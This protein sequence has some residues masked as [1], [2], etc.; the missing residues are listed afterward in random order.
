MSP[1]C[2][3]MFKLFSSAPQRTPVCSANEGDFG[4]SCTGRPCCPVQFTVFI[5]VPLTLIQQWL[6]DL[7]TFE[8]GSSQYYV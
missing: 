5:P 4:R 6:C 8:D 3:K 2:H 1:Q 7:R